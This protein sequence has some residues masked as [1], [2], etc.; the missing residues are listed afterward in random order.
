MDNL[1]CPQ[2]DGPDGCF[3][4]I[5]PGGM[6]DMSGRTYKGEMKNI[7]PKIEWTH[8]PYGGCSCRHKCKRIHEDGTEDYFEPSL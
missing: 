7:L 2:C 8:F 6:A 4:W 5:P 3:H 1:E